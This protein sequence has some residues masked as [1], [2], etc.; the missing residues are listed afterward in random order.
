MVEPDAAVVASLSSVEAQDWD[1][2]D[3]EAHED[4]QKDPLQTDPSCS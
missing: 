4:W 3:E 1:S 2:R